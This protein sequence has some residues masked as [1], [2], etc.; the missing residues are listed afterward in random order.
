MHLPLLLSM[1]GIALCL[2]P[3]MTSFT[4]QGFTIAH[5]GGIQDVIMTKDNTLNGTYHH[6][7]PHVKALNEHMLSLKLIN[8]FSG[9]PINAYIQG[10]DMDGTIVFIN[11][12]GSLVYPSANGS[13]SPVEIK[14][15]I[16]ISLPPKGESLTLNIS[17]PLNSGRV[18][19]S[20]GIFT[21]FML[22]TGNG[23]RLVQ[24]SVNANDPSASLHWGFIEFTYPKDGSIY[25]NISYVD[26][27][28]LILSMI[29]STT[30]GGPPQITRGLRSDAVSHICRGL[31]DQA[32]KDGYSWH[33]MCV[34][35]EE[36]RP[37][38]IISPNYYSRFSGAAFQKY[39]ES[40][41][42]EVW[43]HYSKTP[44]VID[45]QGVFGD[46]ECLVTN[47]ILRCKNDPRA[48]SKPLA[49]DI[50]SCDSGP[51]GR[52]PGDNA[53]HLAVVPRLCAAFVRSTLLIE[54]GHVQPS[55]NSSS[56]YM[57][58]PTNHYSR[59][60]HELQVDGRGYAFPYDDVN[61][62]GDE[63]ASGAVGARDPDTLTIYVGSPP[64]DV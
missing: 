36:R 7:N 61:P 1:A 30:D 26:F 60:V 12:D 4:D 48:F 32:K 2:Q 62:D 25:A 37:V 20:E 59:L 45:T 57:V 58:S 41:V 33:G 23:E 55:L 64:T 10:L 50:W 9:G 19:F 18:Y 40:Y 8:N 15:N 39:W 22:D 29:L 63:N 16:A 38:R 11:A 6:N 54:G 49:T 56:H 24:P 21:F 42:D 52:Q 51:F 35:N 43:D 34:L 53:I 13:S 3:H 17:T 14:Q 44:L 31:F 27:V 28:G 5:P 47:Q 46:V